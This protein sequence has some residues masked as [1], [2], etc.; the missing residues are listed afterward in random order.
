LGL[1]ILQLVENK[2]HRTVLIANFA[3]FCAQQKHPIP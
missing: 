1:E 3:P 2:H